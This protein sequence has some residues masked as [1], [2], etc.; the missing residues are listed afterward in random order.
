[1]ALPII[2]ENGFTLEF[3]DNLGSNNNEA[4]IITYQ[5][6]DEDE[7]IGQ[8]NGG[9]TY[10]NEALFTTKNNGDFPL[11]ASTTV[12]HHNELIDKNVKINNADETITWTIDVNKSH[13]E[14]GNIILTDNPSNN[15]LILEDTFKKR[16]IKMN[17]NG[18][19]SMGSG[20]IIKQTLIK[21]IKHLKLT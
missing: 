3:D 20:K 16:E 21:E 9:G 15:Q 12:K 19:I 8:T 6:E 10:E 2:N 5:T 11:K 13:S 14:L 4:Y 1:D 17:A 7:I 18:D